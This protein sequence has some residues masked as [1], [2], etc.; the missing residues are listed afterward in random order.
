MTQPTVI[1]LPSTAISSSRR[2]WVS[3]GSKGFVHRL[4]GAL[5]FMAEHGSS[6]RSR[7]GQ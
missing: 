3:R 6:R 2:R 1:Y 5:M 4:M 7:V